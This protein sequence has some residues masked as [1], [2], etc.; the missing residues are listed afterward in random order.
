MI[1]FLR[2]CQVAKAMG[3]MEFTG[4]NVLRVITM[5]ADETEKRLMHL[6][7]VQGIA[8]KDV[9]KMEMYGYSF[10]IFCG[11]SRTSGSASGF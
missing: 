7:D 8:T 2:A 3:N 6:P 11:A 9:T 10:K 5:I 4:E 1:H